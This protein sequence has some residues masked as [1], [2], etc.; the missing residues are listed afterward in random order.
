MVCEWMGREVVPAEERL[1]QLS[2]LVL[3]IKQLL[4]DG[5]PTTCVR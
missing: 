4:T 5:D 3:N 2:L 1:L